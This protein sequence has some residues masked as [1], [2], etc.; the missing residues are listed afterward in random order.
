ME[1]DSRLQ[2]P[3][4]ESAEIRGAEPEASTGA[5]KVQLVEVGKMGEAAHLKNGEAASDN[6]KR[7]IS[8]GGSVI[9]IVFPIQKI[10]EMFGWHVRFS[11]PAT[12]FIYLDFLEWKVKF[13]PAAQHLDLGGEPAN[14]D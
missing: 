13:D 14:F 12:L 11:T 10:G 2:R 5:L 8:L 4:A 3:L 1:Q 7:A 9:L 6:Q